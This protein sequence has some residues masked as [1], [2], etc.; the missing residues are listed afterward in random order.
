MKHDLNQ[1]LQQN[2]MTITSSQKTQLLQFL[3]LIQDWNKVYNLT[4]I[5]QPK[6]MVYLHIIDS[7]MIQPFLKGENMLDVG[8]GAGLPG[9]PLAIIN[10]QQ[11][12]TLLDKNGK[13]T[14][15]LTAVI[16]E[17]GLTNVTIVKSRCEHFQTSSCFDTILSRAFGTLALFVDVTKHL[18]C[19]E[20]SPQ[21]RGQFLAMKGQI[22]H[23]EI[24]DLPAGCNILGIHELKMHGIT[25]ERHLIRIEKMF[26]TSEEG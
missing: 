18:V 2:N 23:D 15:F 3:K 12:W 17:C 16:A 9:I 5:T 20:S 7:L 8:S 6:E 10:P 11:K 22:P 24:K 26:S 14:R 4:A 1:A 19:H 13:K 25:L 21:R